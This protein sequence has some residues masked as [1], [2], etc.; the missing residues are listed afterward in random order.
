MIR[1]SWPTFGLTFVLVATVL[2]TTTPGFVVAQTAEPS[3]FTATYGD[4]TV[5]CAEEQSAD[6]VAVRHCAMEQHFV[7][8]EGETGPSH[9]LLTVTL[10][11]S[12]STDGVMEATVLAPFGLLFERGLRLRPDNGRE[13][14]LPFRTCLPAGCIAYG[15]LDRETVRALRAGAVLH[16]QADPA[17]GGDPF[18]IQ[19]SLI[20][21]DAARARLLDETRR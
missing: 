16:V 4:W 15:T 5:R 18:L 9:D 6:G 13:T 14:A 21:F 19:G 12:E 1:E 11:A 8:R 17:A 20:G 10:T 2:A 7:W 3:A